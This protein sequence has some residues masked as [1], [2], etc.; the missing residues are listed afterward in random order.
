MVKAIL[1]LVVMVFL[2]SLIS[3]M[4]INTQA[5]AQTP[6]ITTDK[7]TYLS[8]PDK[9]FTISG[10]TGGATT[11]IMRTLYGPAGYINAGTI[12]QMNMFSSGGVSVDSTGHFSMQTDCTSGAWPP[13]QYR[14]DLSNGAS[15]IASA[16]FTVTNPP[17]NT[18][19]VITIWTSNDIVKTT[20]PTGAIVGG[21]STYGTDYEDSNRNSGIKV[22]DNVGIRSN[23]FT[24]NPP[25]G[26]L[27]HLGATTV[28][29]TATDYAGNV[30]TGTFTV[31]V[32]NDVSPPVVSVPSNQII[33]A[34]N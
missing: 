12:G 29:C 34:T 30:G 3:G 23:S 11:N 4:F 17:D 16:P 20:D 8:P 2:S 31:T 22:T 10:Y 19:P 27:F 26:S 33:N 14:F 9:C 6:Q 32:T 7:Q 1:G 28:T 18:P 25:S 13:G 15:V 5:F 21:T 24:C